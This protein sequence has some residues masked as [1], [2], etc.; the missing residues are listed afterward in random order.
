MLPMQD[1][2]EHRDK[3]NNVDDDCQHRVPDDDDR[4]DHDADDDAEDDTE[5]DHHANDDEHENDTSDD[6]AV[7]DN[8]ATDDDAVTRMM[9]MMMMMPG[10]LGGCTQRICMCLTLIAIYA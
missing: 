7:E 2:K 6:N 1:K 4:V 8:D 5:D 10:C 9:F 3:I